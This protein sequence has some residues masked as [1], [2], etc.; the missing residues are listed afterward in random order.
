MYC[1][2]SKERAELEEKSLPLE[3]AKAGIDEYFANNKSR[4]IRFYGPGEPTMEFELMQQI[5]DYARQKGGDAVTTELQ[6]NGAFS[7]KVREWILDNLNI[8]WISFDGTP[9]IQ[10]EQRPFP[11]QKPSAPTI[12]DN[13]KW[14][15]AN[16]GERNLMVGARVTMTDLNV[17]HQKEMVDYFSSL[18]IQYIWTDPIFPEV[19]KRPVCED[20]D[21]EEMY[22]IDL[23]VYVKNF[24]EAHRYAKQKGVFYGS[25]LT[26]NFDGEAKINCRACTPVPHLTTDGYVSACDMA[27]DGENAYH[28]NCFIYGKWDRQNKKFT[29]FEDK[30]KTLQ[31]R[32]VDNLPHCKNCIA[33][34]HCAGHC[35]GE[36]QNATGNINGQIPPICNAVRTLY[37]ELGACEKYEYMHP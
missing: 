14:L 34:L 31:N 3:I 37:K 10:N 21:R 7:P 30:I 11:N 25:F 26:C 15:Y 35:L 13:I 24:I 17:N 33:K 4:H 12:E 1:Y 28:M 36:V 20:K 23:E 9:D 27:L 2:N 29:Y 5:T 22:H 19:K 18:S 16:K 8:V 32:N 6:T